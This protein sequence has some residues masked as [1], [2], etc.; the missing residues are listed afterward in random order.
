MLDAGFTNEEFDKLSESQNRSDALVRLE[1]VAMHAVKGQFDDG[2]GTFAITGEPDRERAIAL[3]HGADYHAAKAQIMEP[4]SEFMRMIDRRTLTE[5]A[6]LNAREQLLEIVDIA[7]AVLLLL[8]TIAS[9]WLIKIRVLQPIETLSQVA[10]RVSAGDMTARAQLTGQNE[11][12]TFGHTFDSMVGAVDQHLAEVEAA[13]ATLAEQTISLEHERQR[14]EKLLLNV[15]PAAIADRLKNGEDTIAE[16]YP[17]VTVLFSDIVGFTEMCGQI[18]AKQVVDMLNEVF[19]MLDELAIKHD[20]E[21]IKTIG[22]CYMVVAGVPNRSPTHAQQIAMFAL[23]MQDTLQTYAARS[24]R[25]LTMRTGIHTG[26]VVAGIVGTSKFA[27]DLWGDVVNI[28]SRMESSSE[29]GRIQVSDAVRVRLADDFLFEARGD[30][31]IKGK[32]MMHT[33]YLAGH[34]TDRSQA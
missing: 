11:L 7:V 26:T 3:L 17:E 18:G 28:A 1:D 6:S 25:D 29:P 34:R 24:G 8:G 33:W 12:A 21:K 4:I 14:S 2:T 13:R 22:D 32:G 30:V 15:L 9:I 19:G 5:V 20:I 27:Y 31:D 10:D 23:E 16:S